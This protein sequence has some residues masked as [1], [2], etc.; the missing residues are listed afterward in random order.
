MIENFFSTPIYIHTVEDTDLLDIEIDNVVSSAIFKNDWQPDN[1]TAE[2]TFSN[3]MMN[4]IPTFDMKVT[5]DVIKQHVKNYLEQTGQRYQTDSINVNSSWLNKFSTE[6]LIGFHEHGYQ[7]NVV[8]GVYYHKFTPGSGDIQFKSPNPFVVSFPHQTPTYTNIVN[9]AVEQS[10]LLL[11]P[12]WLLHKVM[13]NRT[14]NTRIS[15][16][17]NADFRYT[18]QE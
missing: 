1:D 13:P 6:Q 7:P 3:D 12:N 18:Y 16:A 4:I 2:T 15:L 9:I 11:F 10:M 17:F 14:T 8:S 5:N